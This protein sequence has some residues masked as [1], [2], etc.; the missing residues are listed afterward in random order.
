MIDI[1][2]S[3][4][5]EPSEKMVIIGNKYENNDE[6]I[7]F[8]LPQEFDSYSKYVIAVMKKDT[9]NVTKIFP[10]KDSSLIVSSELT[11]LAGR[12]YLYLMCRDHE[13]DVESEDIDISAKNGEHVF[14]SDGFIGVVKD[15]YL[16]KEVIDNTPMD[17]NLQIV[18]DELVQLK[19]DLEDIVAGSISWDQILDKPSNFPPSS[20]NHDDLY[21]TESEIDK[22]FENISTDKIEGITNEEIE[23]LFREKNWRLA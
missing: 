15:N 4:D 20:H 22:K 8:I 21:Y 18:Y 16:D 3:S 23:S 11:H 14:I 17:T 10:V 9:G 7:H 5:G 13:I 2:Y 12:W 1:I 19:K 6:T